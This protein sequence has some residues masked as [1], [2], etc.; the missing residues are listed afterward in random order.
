MSR[1]DGNNRDGT[2]ADVTEKTGLARRGW[3]KGAC[4]GDYDKDRNVDCLSPTTGRM[5]SFTT[6]AT[7]RSKSSRTTQDYFRL[8]INVNSVSHAG[9]QFDKGDWAPRR[10]LAYL[11]FGSKHTVV[12]GAFGCF[13]PPKRI[14][15]TISV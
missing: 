10:G 6:T 12:R 13:I 4:V 2:F 8:K 5:Y 1:L 3:G 9:V 15:S 14:F 7:A 11:T